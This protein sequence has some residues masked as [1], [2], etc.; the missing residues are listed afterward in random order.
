MLKINR[1]PPQGK[2]APG[3][4]PIRRKTRFFKYDHII[5]QSVAN[6]LYF[7]KNMRTLCS[8][9]I[10][11]TPQ[12]SIAPWRL[13]RGENIK[14]SRFR[15]QSVANF[16][17]VQKNKRTV[18]QKSNTKS[19]NHSKISFSCLPTFLSPCLPPYVQSEAP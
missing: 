2:I 7:Q 11:N 4:Q 3:G 6:F 13:A 5:Y 15:Y 18:Y 12:G 1:K 16:V 10:E 8:K 9:T 19:L 17:Y 14:V